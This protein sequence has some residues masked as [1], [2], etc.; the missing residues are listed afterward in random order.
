M[1]SL[2]GVTDSIHCN[3]FI[4]YQLSPGGAPHLWAHNNTTPT[5]PSINVS[6]RTAWPTPSL[7]LT[8]ADIVRADKGVCRSFV[9]RAKIRI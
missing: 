2:P 7:D 9:L 5:D 4:S 1:L 6:D 3:I 8:A